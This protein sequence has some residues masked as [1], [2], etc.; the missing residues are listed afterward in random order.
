MGYNQFTVTNVE[1]DYSNKRIVISTNFKLDASSVN[2]K[3]VEL[4]ESE[5]GNKTEYSL[6]VNNKTIIIQF[7][8][9][10]RFDTY[11]LKIEGIVDA[12]KRPLSFFYSDFIYFKSKIR[13]R[14]TIINPVHN[15]TLTDDVVQF[16]IESTL[17]INPDFYYLLEVGTNISFVHSIQSFKIDGVT[18]IDKDAEKQ[19]LIRLAA[20]IRFDGQV[21]ARARVHQN[22]ELFSEW[23]DVISFNIMRGEIDS[24]ETSFMEEF[25]NTHDLFDEAS[26]IDI[27]PLEIMD[28]PSM[29]DK[30]DMLYLEFNK[31]IHVP[32]NEDE[33]S[34]Y[35]K[36]GTAMAFKKDLEAKGL[37]EKIKMNLLVD[38]DDASTLL[39]RPIGCELL[40]N[41]QYTVV[42]KNIE[43]EDGT[44]YSN[45]EVFYNKPTDLYVS[46]DDVK[47]I[48]GSLVPDEVLIKHIS[49]SGKVAMYWA[50]KNVTHASQVPDFSTDDFEEEYYP[51]YKYIEHMSAASALK[52]VYLGMI[53]QPKK[54][55]DVL[56]DLQREEEFDFGALKAFIDGIQAEAD[57][58]LKLVVT[59]TADPKWALRGRHFYS[60][61]NIRNHPYHN[62]SWGTYPNNNFDRGF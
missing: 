10:P 18:A 1:P 35:T 56:S 51:F 23:S 12:L 29:T 26:F 6:I 52:E 11:Y 8:D 48:T 37:K 50:K 59:I 57:D 31:D 13:D 25:V 16:N 46:I 28:R 62:T 5:I 53:T 42:L 41:C 20:E 24:L 27:V 2:T 30:H 61:F 4:F 34:L 32:I 22:D 44:T 3:T 14:L 40:E 17:D 38:P 60:K 19:N 45:K 21:Y 49:E 43:F 55:R 9:F 58:W 7:D 15:E 33:D 36:I 54:W 47:K 39:M